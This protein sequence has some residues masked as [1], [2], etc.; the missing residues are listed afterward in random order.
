MGSW[1]GVLNQV[2]ESTKSTKNVPRLV[3]NSTYIAH[4]TP[5]FIEGLLKVQ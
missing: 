2:E 3:T 5:L 1:F 4:I